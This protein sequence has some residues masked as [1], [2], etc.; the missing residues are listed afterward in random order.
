M[1]SEDGTVSP[2]LPHAVHSPSFNDEHKTWSRPPCFPRG[3][4]YPRSHDRAETRNHRTVAPSKEVYPNPGFWGFD[5]VAFSLTL[6][7]RP[8]LQR[9]FSMFPNGWPGRGLLLLR[10]GAGI[11]LTHDGVAEMLMAPEWHGII[12]QSLATI[13]GVLLLIG[14]FTPMAAVLVVIVE[15]WTALSRADNLRTCIVLAVVGAAL[16]MLGPGIWSLDARL[17]GRKRIDIDDR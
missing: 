14:F 15:V 11:V 10:L 1:N 13:G 9:L 16:A 7:L 6:S 5:C 8:S 3:I 4:H 12:W 17:F 2:S